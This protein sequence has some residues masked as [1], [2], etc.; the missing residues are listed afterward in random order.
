[1]VAPILCAEGITAAATGF[2]VGPLPAGATFDPRSAVV[3]WI[4]GLA[5]AGI[6]EIGV[7]ASNGDRGTLIITVADRF[8]SARNVPLASPRAYTEEMGLPVLHLTTD[9]E[10]NADHYTPATVLHAGKEYSAE[11]KYRGNSSLSYPKKNFTLRFS[12]QEPFDGGDRAGGF[13]GKRRISLVS[14]FDDNS[15]LRYRLAYALWDRLGDRIRV[16][17]FS[18]VVYLDGA[19]QGLYTV[20]DHIDE[21]LFAAHGLKRAGNVYKS[22]GPSAN[23]LWKDIVPLVY[24]KTAGTPAAGQPGAFDDLEALIAFVAETPDETFRAEVADRI[25]LGDHRAWFVLAT[26]IQARDSLGKNV[27]H[28]HDPTGGPWR[29]VIWDFNHSFGQDWMTLREGPLADPAE[30]A[31][32]NGL[33]RRF[34]GDAVLG[35][36][37][38]ADYA[39]AIAERMPVDDVID[40][41]D[42]MAREIAPSARRDERRWRQQ[43]LTFERWSARTDFTN[44][45]GEIEYLRNWIRERWAYL[46]GLRVPVPSGP[47]PARH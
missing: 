26:A 14:S 9:A 3:R 41:M 35:P 5:Q 30:L 40:T 47:E 4:P 7:V 10:I 15:Y 39:R 6:Y 24:E 13:R 17:T 22:V 28:Y 42:A 31:Q 32:G 37:T 1:M 44:F 25:D 16:Q 38:W 29:V 18:A 34:V 20:V 2:T 36:E 27:Y 23:L 11:A 33:F 45:A 46:A 12:R 43:H 19:Y 21:D 8:D